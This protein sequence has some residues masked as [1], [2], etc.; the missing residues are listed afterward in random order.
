MMLHFATTPPRQYSSSLKYG[1]QNKPD[2]DPLRDQGEAGYAVS[3]AQSAKPCPVT[4]KGV[5]L[6]G[7]PT[8]WEEPLPEAPAVYY[9]QDSMQRPYWN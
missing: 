3:V 8:I 7:V 9:Q 5:F 1:E 4:L 6:Q 2:R